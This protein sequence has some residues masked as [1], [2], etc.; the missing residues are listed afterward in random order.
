LK[1][2]EML[3]AFEKMIFYGKSKGYKFVTIEKMR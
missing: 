1:N 2:K 3:V